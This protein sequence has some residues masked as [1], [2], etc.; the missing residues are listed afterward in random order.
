MTPSQELA[1]EQ[2][3]DAMIAHEYEY[4][5]EYNKE[6]FDSCSQEIKNQSEPGWVSSDS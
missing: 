5:K 1:F 2:Y 4:Q 3:A 6:R